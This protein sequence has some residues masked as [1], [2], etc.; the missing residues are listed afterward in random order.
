[1]KLCA[2]DVTVLK[3]VNLVEEIFLKGPFSLLDREF[4]IRLLVS[5]QTNSKLAHAELRS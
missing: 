2:K 3:S 4:R 5:R 1:M